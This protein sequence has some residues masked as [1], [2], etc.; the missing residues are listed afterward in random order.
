M[1]KNYLKEKQ[2]KQNK[3]VCH[4]NKFMFRFNKLPKQGKPREGQW[5]VLGREIFNNG[6]EADN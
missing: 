4:H 2:N 5:T 6:T 1:Q 3:Q